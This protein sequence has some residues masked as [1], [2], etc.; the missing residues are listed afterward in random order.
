MIGWRAMRRFGPPVAEA[1]ALAMGK[2]QLAR[3]GAAL[4]ERAKRLH[5]LGPPYAALVTRRIAT[6][7]GIREAD[8]RAREDAV[9]HQLDARGIAADFA[10]TAET[11]RQ[12]RTPH[13]L[14]RA[15]GALRT[16][17]RTLAR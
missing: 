15:A 16:I 13:E 10:Q 1:P 12:A 8:P 14:L 7:L 6:S 4:V 9:A 11:L 3:N 5:L 2:R 17:E